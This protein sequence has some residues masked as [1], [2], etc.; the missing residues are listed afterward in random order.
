MAREQIF[1][2]PAHNVFFANA[3][4]AKMKECGHDVEVVIK[5]QYE[6]MRMLERVI[7]SDLLQKNKAEGKSMKKD[8]K[9]AFF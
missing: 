8:E 4:F 1:G 7:L 2:D 9:I 5:D 6:V 3:L